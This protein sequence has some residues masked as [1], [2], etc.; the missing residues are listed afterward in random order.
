MAI[1]HPSNI[2]E[3]TPQY[4]ELVVYNALK[5]QLPDYYD[6]FW[7]VEWTERKNGKVEKCND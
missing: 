4:S 6:V 2:N 1:M 5:T 3:Y 7:S